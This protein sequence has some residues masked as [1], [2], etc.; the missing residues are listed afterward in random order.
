MMT[1]YIWR[2]REGEARDYKSRGRECKDTK[3]KIWIKGSQGSR[4]RESGDIK[5]EKRIHGREKGWVQDLKH[6]FVGGDC[7][8]W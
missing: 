7:E 2:V 4:F 5:I 8:H 3:I 1:K 6:Y